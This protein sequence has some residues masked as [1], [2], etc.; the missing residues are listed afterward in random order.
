MVSLQFWGLGDGRPAVLDEDQLDLLTR[1]RQH[2]YWNEA[3]GWKRRLNNVQLL[4]QPFIYFCSIK[5]WLRVFDIPDL[6]HG[7]MSLIERINQ[8]PGWLPSATFQLLSSA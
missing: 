5:P 3:Q 8:F 4:I 6:Q 2:R 7:F 1:F